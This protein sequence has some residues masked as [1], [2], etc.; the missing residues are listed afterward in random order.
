MILK[1]HSDASYLPEAKARSRHVGLLY[2]GNINADTMEENNGALLVPSTQ[3]PR[4]ASMPALQNSIRE[5]R[6][7]TALPTPTRLAQGTQF[8]SVTLHNFFHTS[9]TAQPIRELISTS[10]LQWFRDP[11]SNL[12]SP[13]THSMHRAATHQQAIG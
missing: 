5:K 2:L 1:Q 12:R 11:T 9:N 4:R 8:L 7:P 13:H 10:L 3:S 6:P